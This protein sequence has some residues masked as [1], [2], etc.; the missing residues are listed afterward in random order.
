[1]QSKEISFR[2]FS[3]LFP[4]RADED[5][6][7]SA[8]TV[9]PFSLF[10]CLREISRGLRQFEQTFAFRPI[11]SSNRTEFGAAIPPA[12]PLSL[13]FREYIQS[14]QRLHTGFSFP[15]FPLRCQGEGELHHLEQASSSSSPLLP[16]R[17]M[18]SSYT[19]SLGSSPPPLF[20]SSIVDEASCAV[21]PSSLFSH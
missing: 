5:A 4:Q 12:S 8:R 10:F 17:L 19:Y 9:L 20:P 15:S 13:S 2:F 18:L 14:V 16:L 6:P 1:L 21:A 3:L 7:G 11:R